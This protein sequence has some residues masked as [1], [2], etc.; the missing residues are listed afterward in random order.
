M[1]AFFPGLGAQATT[2]LRRLRASLDVTRLPKNCWQVPLNM[3]V[4]PPRREIGNLLLGRNAIFRVRRL[5]GL[6]LS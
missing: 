5:S 1:K 3:I 2:R 6:S 4:Y